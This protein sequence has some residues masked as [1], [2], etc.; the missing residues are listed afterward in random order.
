MTTE[1]NKFADFT[2]LRNA[3]SLGLQPNMT[4]SVAMAWKHQT[5]TLDKWDIYML[6]WHNEKRKENCMEATWFS[7][8]KFETNS[9][10]VYLPDR[11]TLM[12]ELH[13]G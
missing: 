11:K 10:W 12:K 2:Y 6:K 3:M 5:C 13:D 4:L 8:L 1:I 7:T 9:D